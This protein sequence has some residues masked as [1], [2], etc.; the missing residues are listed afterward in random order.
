MRTNN[1]GSG[2]SPLFGSFD[3]PCRRM[4]NTAHGGVAPRHHH[5]SW[6]HALHDELTQG[7]GQSGMLGLHTRMYLGGELAKKCAAG[8]QLKVSSTFLLDFHPRRTTA[9][10]GAGG[11]CPAHGEKYFLFIYFIPK[12]TIAGAVETI[13]SSTAVRSFIGGGQ[14]QR[15][16]TLPSLATEYEAIQ[17][18]QITSVLVMACDGWRSGHGVGVLF[19]GATT[20]SRGTYAKKSRIRSFVQVHYNQR[21]STKYTV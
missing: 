10:T 7:R 5:V 19:F 15:K 13:Q 21:S 9:A 6:E 3:S 11:R 20:S 16:L 8:D 17:D 1:G 14:V 4:Q 2:E 12:G 18:G